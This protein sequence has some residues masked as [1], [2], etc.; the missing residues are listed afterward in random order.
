MKLQDSS[1]DLNDPDVKEQI[2]KQA[3]LQNPPISHKIQTFQ[4]TN[5]LVAEQLQLL[6]PESSV[7]V[8]IIF[9]IK[10]K[11]DSKENVTLGPDAVYVS[12]A[13]GFR[14]TTILILNLLLLIIII[15]L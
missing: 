1:V 3:S 11:N 4:Q 14:Q 5:I 2:L 12:R 7:H 13:A 6:P 10:T 8:N 9:L 15:I